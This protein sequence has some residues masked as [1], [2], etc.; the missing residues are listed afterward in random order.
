MSDRKLFRC[1]DCKKDNI[2]FQ[3]W[4]DEFNVVQSGG[5]EDN[6]CWCNDC[7]DHATCELKEKSNE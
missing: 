1:S 2:E 6:Y 4:A 3:V 5:V 7:E